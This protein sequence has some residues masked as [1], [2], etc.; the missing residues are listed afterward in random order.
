MSATGERVFLWI[1]SIVVFGSF[2]GALIQDISPAK[3]SPL[4][5]LLAYPPLVALHEL[6]HALAARLLGWGVREVVIGAGPRWRAFEV[7]GVP[8]EIKRVPLSGYVRLRPPGQLTRDPSRISHALIYLAGPLSEAMVIL[9]LALLLGERLWTPSGHVGIICAQAVSA[10]A[11]FGVITNLLPLRMAD[12][13][14][15][16]GL[17]ALTALSFTEGDYA[18][19][20]MS[21]ELEGAARLLAQG[22]AREALVIFEV[23]SERAPS[24]LAAHLGE[25]DALVA[26]GRRP[27]AILRLAALERA[28]LSLTQRRRVRLKLKEIRRQREE[29]APR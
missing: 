10:A 8:V 25:A 23:L 20:R 26:L 21:Q 4:F 22:A 12:G 2:L 27:E 13:A 3:L 15:S 19:W 6:G 17:G 1:F 9:L 7:A 14:L 11:A 18:E 5:F 24:A 16:D 28:A 29:G